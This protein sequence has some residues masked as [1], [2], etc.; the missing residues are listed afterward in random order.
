MIWHTL[1]S[2]KVVSIAPHQPYSQFIISSTHIAVMRGLSQWAPV[3]ISEYL[4]L[5]EASEGY[6]SGI[7][8]E[9][10]TE[11]LDGKQKVLGVL[12]LPPPK[13][14]TFNWPHWVNI[15]NVPGNTHPSFIFCSGLLDMSVSS[16]PDEFHTHW[17]EVS[18]LWSKEELFS[19]YR[20]FV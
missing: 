3:C 16:D 7:P 14:L 12:R 8:W 17:E 2:A 10:L 9:G 13:S 1:C 4:F 20:T 6:S 18:H 5:L 19:F 15:L 11:L